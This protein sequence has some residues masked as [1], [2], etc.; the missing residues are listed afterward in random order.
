LEAFES[1]SSNG[2]TFSAI[3]PITQV[4]IEAGIVYNLATVV[5]T[6]PDVQLSNQYIY[7]SYNT[8]HNLHCTSRLLDLHN[9]TFGTKSKIALMLIGEFQDDNGDG[10]AQIGETILY[11]T[12]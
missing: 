7:R 2:T 4:D 1:N 8:M 3:Y 11:T 9:D 10:Q 12:Q 5:G 6:S